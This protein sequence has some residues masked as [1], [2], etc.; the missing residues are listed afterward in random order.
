MKILVA[1]HLPMQLVPYIPNHNALR[2]VSVARQ[3]TSSLA[4]S[5]LPVLAPE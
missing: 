2:A 1:G 5:F 4:M 3:A